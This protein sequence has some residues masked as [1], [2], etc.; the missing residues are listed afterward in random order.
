M[1]LIR[2]VIHV[3][4]LN[5]EATLYVAMPKGYD[6]T[7]KHYPTIYMLDGQNVFLAN[8]AYQGETWGVME[9][10]EN[11]D[12]LPEVMVVGLSSA[13]GDARLDEYGPFPFTDY[14]HLGGRAETTLDYLIDELKPAIDAQYRTMPEAEHTAIAGASMGGL[15]ALYATVH[16]PDVFGMA[17]SLSGAFFVSE[18]PLLRL[19][20]T[21]NLRS[22]R[23]IYVDTGDE[24][25]AGGTPEDYLA[26]NLRVHEALK[27]KLPQE[28]LTF[29]IIGAGRH[30][31]TDWAM[32]FPD[33]V[34]TL[35]QTN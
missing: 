12:D 20:E 9:A 28:K 6:D 26:S 23:R 21:S 34:R 30:F 35:F 3:D 29:R 8:D 16:R 10:Y 1:K 18:A 32:R 33:V 5:R 25:E 19:I 27:D 4:A 13:T 14:R 22:V 31:E 15:F 7:D 11:H 17:A 24:E 2:K